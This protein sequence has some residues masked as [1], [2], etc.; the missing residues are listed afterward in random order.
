MKINIATWFT[1]LRL[2]LVPVIITVILSSWSTTRIS[3]FNQF[4]D[5][6]YFIAGFIFV[7]GSMTDFIDGYLARKLGQVTDLG[8]FLDPI[9]DKLF[10][11]STIIVLIG[12]GMISPLF[13]IIFIGRDTIVDVIRML[14]SSK[15]YVVAASKY[16]KLKTIFQM[17]GIASVLFFNIPFEAIGFPMSTVLMYI[18]VF[19]AVYSG[20]DYYYLNK[21]YI[22]GEEN[23]EFE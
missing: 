9:A 10:V 19:F 20:I 22:F 1:I 8:K 14:A 7:I 13:G 18:A 23:K 11:N 21:K 17:M 4:I 12:Q 16:G 2:L 5:F 15:G 6:K 3:V